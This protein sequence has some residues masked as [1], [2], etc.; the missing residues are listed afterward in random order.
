MKK[1]CRY[2]E[3]QIQ[4]SGLLTEERF[5]EVQDAV[6][7]RIT[8][9]HDRDGKPIG[10]ALVVHLDNGVRWLHPNV[11]ADHAKEYVRTQALV[12]VLTDEELEL[13]NNHC[14]EAGRTRREAARFEKAK[15]VTEWGEG[16]WL[17]DTYHHTMAEL[18]EYLSSEEDEWPEYVWAARPQTVIGKIDAWD[19]CESMVCDQ[20]WEDMDHHDLHGLTELQAALDK[21]TEANAGVLSYET[22]YTIAVLLSGYKSALIGQSEPSNQ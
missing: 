8:P 17:G 13:I 12:A 22:D 11:E 18:L 10:H 14:L 6:T 7:N 3:S 1:N 4:A 16:A 15:K 21:F 20:G 5:R 19:C 9:A 2:S